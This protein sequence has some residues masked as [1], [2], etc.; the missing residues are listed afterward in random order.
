MLKGAEF[1]VK[2]EKS[3]NVFI[4]EEWNEE[5]LMIKAW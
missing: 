5:Q 4:P 1:I 2:N 3:K